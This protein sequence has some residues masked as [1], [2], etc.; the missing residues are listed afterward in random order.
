MKY[1]GQCHC[2]E[3]AFS[4]EGELDRA[5]DCNCSISA[6]SGYLHWMVDPAQVQLKTP[7][8]K[9]TLYVWEPDRPDTGF[10]RNAESRSSAFRAVCPTGTPSTFVVLRAFD[11]E[12][13]PTEHFDG[14]NKLKV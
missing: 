1:E 14:R 7:L 3:I 13:I 2:G 8:E 12:R 6:Q 10:V 11:V 9:A 5:L 4:V